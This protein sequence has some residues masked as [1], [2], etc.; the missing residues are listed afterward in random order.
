MIGRIRIAP[1]GVKGRT[2][3]PS[4]RHQAGEEAR[5]SSSNAGSCFGERFRRIFGCE[6]MQSLW[7]FVRGY[8]SPSFVA[9]VRLIDGFF[10]F[11]QTQFQLCD[12]YF[13]LF[14]FL[15]QALYRGEGNAVGIHRRDM[16]AV[17][18]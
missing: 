16:F 8:Q 18:P 6:G 10:E 13:L 11:F 4:A 12:L 5:A 17:S 15:I 14:Q 3:A 1:T 7:W 2:T 9:S